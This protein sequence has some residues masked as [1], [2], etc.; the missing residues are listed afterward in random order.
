MTRVGIVGFGNIGKGVYEAI[1]AAPDFELA[2]VIKHKR[3]IKIPK[4]DGPEVLVVD[5]GDIKKLGK[6]DIV[7]LCTPSRGV[8]EIAPQYHELGISTVDSYDIH[9]GI[10]DLKT[11]FDIS[12]KKNNVVSLLSVG[13]DPGSDSIIRA[14]FECMAPQGKTYTNFGPGMSMGH[15]VAVKAVKGVK[16]ALS[17]TIP[18]GEGLHR[19]MVYIEIEDGFNFDE[20]ADNIKKDP[21][22]VK[23]ETHVFK[24]NN[25]DSIID[26]GH[27]SHIL[28]KGVSGIT[29][30]QFFEYRS[31]ANNPALT[32]QVMLSS[33]R[34]AMKQK[35]G[36]YTMIEIPTIDYLYGEKEDLI[37]HLV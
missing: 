19:R 1:S 2:G 9:D 36:C 18:K 7:I 13:W 5:M 15:T 30:N 3:D 32:A 8:A 4:G 17:V 24:E 29:H 6:V 20:V 25:V 33:A 27:A 28:R 26:L 34:A 16:K 23:D 11:K 22:F 14:L 12:T 21:Y 31:K 37:R 10:W 35:P